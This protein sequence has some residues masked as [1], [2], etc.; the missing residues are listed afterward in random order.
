MPISEAATALLQ[1]RYLRAEIE[2]LRISALQ[3]RMLGRSMDVETFNTS[4]LQ[5]NLVSLARA[6]RR[7]A[8]ST[9]GV[10]DSDVRNAARFVARSYEQLAEARS[11]NRS[12]MLMLAAV[13]YEL[14]GYQ[15]NAA[16]LARLASDVSRLPLTQTP[17]LEQLVSL[18]LQRRFLRLSRSA[19]SLTVARDVTVEAGTVL[20]AA[21]LLTQQAL[22]KASTYFLNGQA[23]A[24][25]EAKD[26]LEV[27]HGAMVEIGA[28]PQSLLVNGLRSILPRLETTSIWSNLWPRLP[29]SRLW[30]RYLMTLGRG[31]GSGGVLDARSISELW[32]SQLRALNEGILSPSS[33][34]VRMPTSAGKTR[35]AEMAI[36]H[37]LA[38]RPGAKALYVG[39]FNAL[40]NEVTAGLNDLFVDLGLSVS[41]LPGNYELSAVDEDAL[42]DDLLVLTP[43]KLDQLLRSNSQ[44]I[45]EI[46]VVVLDEGHV[47]GEDNRGPK[48]ELVISRLRQRRPDTKFV[49]LSAVVPDETLREFSEWLR[50][51]ENPVSSQWRPTEQRLAL[52][53]WK[54]SSGD[55]VYTQPGRMQHQSPERSCSAS[56]TQT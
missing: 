53:R 33:R 11:V 54:G 55:L 30:N 51:S 46:D 23:S 38:V 7:A 48:Y 14:A 50:A 29:E 47:V 15:A 41:S 26:D 43:E 42:D 40:T 17:D 24:L 37:A 22:A 9:E 13:N 39:P 4:R 45:D 49:A 44:F 3:R 12:S 19:D 35:V 28:A 56:S 36:V 5:R 25:L 18:F 27:V 6:V 10:P 52:L 20:E 1:D 21:N 31:M 8:A 2:A 16:T 34:V 32:P